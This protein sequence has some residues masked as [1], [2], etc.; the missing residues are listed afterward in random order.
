M[1]YTLLLNNVSINLTNETKIRL[2]LQGGTG[3]SPFCLVCQLS[4]LEV[5]YILLWPI[6]SGICRKI[7]RNMFPFR[8]RFTVTS[9]CFRNRKNTK[10]RKYESCIINGELKQRYHKVYDFVFSF[11]PNKIPSPPPPK[12]KNT[13]YKIYHQTYDE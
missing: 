6:R 7:K 3:A 8:T 9:N 11:A 10:S 4:S 13:L 2:L 5:L 1:N 12:K